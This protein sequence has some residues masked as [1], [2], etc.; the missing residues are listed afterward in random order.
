MS[1]NID[2]K[3]LTALLKKLK[4]Q[5]NVDATGPHDPTMQLVV[6]FFQWEATTAR[7]DQ[8]VD[9]LMAQMVDVNELRVTPDDEILRLIDDPDELMPQRVRRLRE[10]MHEVFNR[11]HS[12]EMKSAIAS[13]KKEQ[14]LYLDTL[15]A[16]PLYV[17]ANVALLA[18]QAHAMP[19]DQ[20][21]IDALVREGVLKEEDTP[22][23]VE[24]GLLKHIKA[25][26]A[27][28][29]HLLFQAWV[30]QKAAARKRRQS[31]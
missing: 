27:A 3:Q 21:L 5:H 12:I 13:G 2:E 16:V 30:D 31:K 29:A 8:I 19:V 10:A 20:Q 23:E 25:A 24:A 4:G 26:D 22:R 9:Q 15:P 11:E 6:A 28:E 17:A 7:A 14:R 1:A 18:F